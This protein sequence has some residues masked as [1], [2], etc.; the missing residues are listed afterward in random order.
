MTKQRRVYRYTI[1]GGILTAVVFG[2]PVVAAK[3]PGVTLSRNN[4]GLLTFE[5]T[6]LA[7]STTTQLIAGTLDG[8]TTDTKL[9]TV[10]NTGDFPFTVELDSSSCTGAIINR[11][12]PAGTQVVRVVSAR[13]MCNSLSIVSSASGPATGTLT[14]Q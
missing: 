11:G 1:L 5:F 7:P 4:G 8:S 2:S 10:S 13:Q 3:E 6:D 9:V 14:I 12:V